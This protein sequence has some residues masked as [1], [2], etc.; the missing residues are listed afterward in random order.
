M[1]AAALGALA[2]GVG[3]CGDPAPVV[4]AVAEAGPTAP[5]ADAHLV[6]GG[7]PEA[8]AWIARESAG[9]RATVVNLFASWCGP[10]R[11]EAPV[12]RRA[13]ADHPGI[14]FLGVDHIDRRPEG[15]AFL[16][17]EELGFDATLFDVAGDV[18]AGIGARGMPTTAFFDRDGRLVALHTGPLTEADLA[19]RLAELGP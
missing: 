10:C 14:A 11:E 17:E 9:G 7:W 16:E 13:M 12:L 19:E 6:D 15:E 1:V 18:A 8:A 4:D 3:A 2:L 5:P